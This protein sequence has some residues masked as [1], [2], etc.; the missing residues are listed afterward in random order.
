MPW[1]FYLVWT[2]FYLLFLKTVTVGSEFNFRQWAKYGKAYT[3]WYFC[4]EDW[5]H[6]RIS[7]TTMTRKERR[8]K[9][10]ALLAELSKGEGD[11]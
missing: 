7:H 8:R 3:K 6:Y 1:Q 10:D 4:R 11:E 2:M 5:F 9:A